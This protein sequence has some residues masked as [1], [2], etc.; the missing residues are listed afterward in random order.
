MIMNRSSFLLLTALV[1]LCIS[2]DGLLK[3][4]EEKEVIARAGDKFL[5]KKDIEP[6]LKS[7]NSPQD[8]AIIVNNY[9]NN[10]ARR[11]LLLSKAIINLPEEKQ[12]EY[13]KLVAGY[14]ADLYTKAYT[15]ALVAQA[16][17]TTISNSQI[18]QFYQAEKDNFKL[19]ER[20]VKL[21]FVALPNQFLNKEEVVTRF[22]RFEEQDKKFLDSIAVQFKKMHLNDSIW[23]STN[24]VMEEIPALT[25]V[26]QDNYLKKSQFFELQDSLGV[27]LGK[28][29]N[30]LE[31]N[32]VA[33]MSYV[34]PNIKQLILN[35]RKIAF[36]KKLET[37]LLD[38]ALK[39]NEFEI[40]D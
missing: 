4:K 16:Q 1:F 8:S 28:V 25:Y 18:Q 2:C 6:L 36:L 32:D 40:Y 24:R 37:E 29:T 21:R 39:K 26:N 7:S 34:T 15:D 10:W 13:N 35:R 14:K 27:Y 20:L 38:E 23:V 12:E 31:I 19:S 3:P 17:D 22:K 11:E 30:I 33:P 9:I 5:Y